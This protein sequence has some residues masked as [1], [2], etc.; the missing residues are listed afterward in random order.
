[1]SLRRELA[2]LGSWLF[3][4]ALVVAALLSSMDELS[5]RLSPDSDD[6]SGFDLSSVSSAV[7]GIVPVG[8]PVFL[9]VIGMIDPDFAVLPLIQLLLY[10]CA[11]ASLFA[12]LRA[13]G[14]QFV[15]A[16][17]ATIPLLLN[18]LARVYAPLMLS[19]SLGGA[20]GILTVSG[21]LMAAR[22]PRSGLWIA[23]IGAL[24]FASYQ[25]RPAYLFLIPAAPVIVAGLA[26]TRGASRKDIARLSGWTAVA[27][28]APYVLFCSLRWILVG[29]WGLVS[30]GGVNLMGITASLL[31]ERVVASAPSPARALAERILSARSRLEL[32]P[33]LS[34]EDMTFVERQLAW[35]DEYNVNVWSIAVPASLELVTSDSVAQDQALPL[36]NARI[37]EL[38][39]H[40]LAQR[41]AG[42]LQWVLGEF[43]FGI[44]R[45]LMDRSVTFWLLIPL[46]L[47]GLAATTRRVTSGSWSKSLANAARGLS[48]LAVLTGAHFISALLLVALV[49]Y[50]LPRY[51]YAASVF[52]PGLMC[53]LTWELARD[54][55]SSARSP[56]PI[57]N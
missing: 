44:Y 56:A 20:C 5:L 48:A 31:D 27:G 53:A 21:M 33:I 52:V 39:R 36:A 1:M 23:A 46:I 17:V 7:S 25:V 34:R 43:G 41:P 15:T 4:S 47:A 42:Y 6:Y 26:W 28:A 2:Y 29:H 13:F 22:G 51:L 32:T 45:T 14:M 55:V 37:S 19:D 54:A 3:L 40:I 8:Y 24:A 38:S 10:W 50:T 35:E 30:M 18:P 49:E 16:T 57:A 9:R 11:V 12:A